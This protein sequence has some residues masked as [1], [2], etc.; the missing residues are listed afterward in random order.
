MQYCD[1]SAS[2]CSVAEAMLKLFLVTQK[3]TDQNSIFIF[4]IF[5]FFIFKL[6]SHLNYHKYGNIHHPETF[7]TAI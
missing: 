6:L 5:L 1:E 7:N 2:Y 3:L 4:I